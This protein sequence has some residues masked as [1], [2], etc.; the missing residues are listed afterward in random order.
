MATFYADKA[1]DGAQPRTLHA[2]ANVVVSTVT[3]GS[4]E[5][6]ESATAA[7]GDV[8]RFVK[9]PNGATVYRVGY[10]AGR[11]VGAYDYGTSASAA[12]FAD[13]ASALTTLALSTTGL[14]YRVS[15][16]DDASVAYEYLQGVV[17]T[18]GHTAGDTV[19]VICEYVLDQ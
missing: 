1:E 19:T 16:S 2:G 12:L 7:A 11:A 3:F 5:G 13:S 14:P 18:A 10:T 15:I 6:D 8:I 9:L 4:A 17:Q